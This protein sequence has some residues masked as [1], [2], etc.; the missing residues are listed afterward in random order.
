MRCETLSRVG[1]RSSQVS[2]NIG[3]EQLCAPMFTLNRS[4]FASMFDL[5]QGLTGALQ[6]PFSTEGTCNGT[7]ARI[8]EGSESS[9]WHSL[10]LRAY[11]Q[12]G[13]RRPIPQAGTAWS[14]PS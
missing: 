8:E 3:F 12:V 1:R 9:L 13:G 11:R 2:L 14:L 7:E 10:L 6:R 4:G 5:A